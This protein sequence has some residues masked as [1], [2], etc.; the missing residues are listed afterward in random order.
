MSRYLGIDVG[1]TTIAAVVLDTDTGQVVARHSIANDSR[2]PDNKQPPGRSEWDIDRMVELALQLL[3]TVAAQI[4]VERI[5]GDKTYLQQMI[6][7][8]G[9]GFEHSGCTPA[10]GYMGATLFW[11]QH[12]DLLP[13]HT[14]ACFAPDYLVSR[15]CDRQPVTDPT[16]AASAGLFDVM[17]GTWNDELIASLGL[18]VTHLPPVQPSC[19]AVGHLTKSAATRT[20]LPVGLAVTNGCGDNQASFAGSVADYGRSVLVNIGTGA[21]T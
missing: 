18:C 16:N 20:G 4:D 19:R 1:T 10:T 15:L 3:S 9:N 13:A 21:H 7:L 2:L 17:A 8:A 12:N 14:T 11:L 5:S 6:E